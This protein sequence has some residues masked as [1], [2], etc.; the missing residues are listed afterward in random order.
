MH[1][2]AERVASVADVDTAISAGSGPRWALMGPHLTFHLAG[3]VGGID[4]FLDQFARPMA[5]WWESLGD[6][7]LTAELRQRLAQGIAEEAAGRSI[8]ELEARR[9]LF[10]VDLLALKA[11]RQ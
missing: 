2:V 5:S 11:A 6:P 8:A 9:D 3:G 4:H 10:L 1:L 7:A